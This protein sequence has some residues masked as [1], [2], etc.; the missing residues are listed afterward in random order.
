MEQI[1]MKRLAGGHPS[2]LKY[3]AYFEDSEYLCI[4]T[5]LMS[6]DLRELL[7]QLD[8][9]LSEEQI[10]RLFHQVVEA[11]AHC[12]Q[13]N[14]IHRDIKL[15]NFLVDSVNDNGDILLK[16]SD[17]GLACEYDP[18]DPPQKRCGSLFTIAPE[19]L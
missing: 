17:F 4:V 13:N 15:D 6:T 19:I 5:E 12:H 3:V 18:D 10:K 8:Q 14:I 16:L 1:T 11:V 9:R 7:C 2:I